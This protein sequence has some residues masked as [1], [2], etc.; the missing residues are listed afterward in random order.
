MGDKLAVAGMVNVK[1]MI[2]LNNLFLEFD[3]G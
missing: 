1:H 3:L 2:F